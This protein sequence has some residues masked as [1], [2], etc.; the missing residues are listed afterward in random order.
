LNVRGQ[1]YEW[2]SQIFRQSCGHR[3]L[4]EI[5]SLAAAEHK[6]DAIKSMDC[7]R[8]QRSS[9]KTIGSL[10]F[11]INNK[12]LLIGSHGD[13]PLQHIPTATVAK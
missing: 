5:R 10:N 3:S 1:R 8:K 6:V 11:G 13:A 4:I 2:P 9:A 12:N 7:C